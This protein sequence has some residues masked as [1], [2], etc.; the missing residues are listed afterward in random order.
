MQ[1]TLT[2]P[3]KL[4]RRRFL[5]SSVAAGAACGYFIHPTGVR[6]SRSPNEKLRIGVVGAGGKGWHNVQELTRGELAEQVEMVALCDVDSNKLDKAAE[7]FPNA[8]KYRD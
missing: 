2:R 7:T 1:N 5:A 4:T 3:P 8:R 6:A